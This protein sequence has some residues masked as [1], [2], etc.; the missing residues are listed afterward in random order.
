MIEID[1]AGSGS[2]IGGTIIGVY[3]IE[4]KE[5]TDEIIPLNY[6]SK[7]NMK[8]KA[9]LNYVVKI[10]QRSFKKLDVKENE[11]IKICRGYMF[12][13]LRKWLDKENYI[14]SNTVIDGPLQERVEKRFEE[15]VI[16]LGF[17]EAFIK[18]TKYPFHFHRIL[19]WV[20]ADYDK[21]T[22]LC[23]IGWRSWDKYGN[24]PI[25]VSYDYLPLTREYHCLKCGKKMNPSEKSKILRFKSNRVNEVYLHKNC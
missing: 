21:R 4:T 15:Y 23:K 18:Y 14:W 22:K 9:Y 17:P 12:D 2:F 16:S 19:K 7:T 8:K 6:Y 25:E 13:G 24:L 5:Y 10:I 3:R 20:Y 11:S 1:D